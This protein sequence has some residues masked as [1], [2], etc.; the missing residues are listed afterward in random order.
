M[1]QNRSFEEAPRQ[2]SNTEIL[3]GRTIKSKAMNK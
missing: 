1:E 3:T 2:R